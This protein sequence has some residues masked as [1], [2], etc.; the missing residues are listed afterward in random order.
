MKKCYKCNVLINT[1]VQK[2]PLCNG[3]IEEGEK[4]EN[5]F[6]IIPNIY[7]K[8]KLFFKLLLFLSVLGSFISLIVNYLVSN[9]ISWS[10][11][12]IA[13]IASFWM[14]FITGIKKRHNFMN[15]LFFEALIIL[16]S[17][18]IWDYFTGW[19][20]WS[21]TYV[22][23]FLCI[24]YITILFFLRIFLKNIFKDHV[25]YI[26]INS[27]IGLMPLYFILRNRLSIKWPSIVCVIFSI[28]SI[29]VLAIFNHK[30][31]KNELE[32]RLHI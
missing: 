12:V 23:P 29:L 2:C 22:L 13:G 21:I 18:I 16:I 19:Y 3:S 4:G 28:F 32:R 31:M 6:P 11:F 24:A 8:H 5:I 26:Y 25:I 10:W 7:I 17:S 27:L 9:K 15:L 14:T 30:Q 1:K 20:F